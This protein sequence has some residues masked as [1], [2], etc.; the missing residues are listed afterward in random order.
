[1]VYGMITPT[2]KLKTIEIVLFLSANLL[3]VAI[4]L[5]LYLNHLNMLLII[6]IIGGWILLEMLGKYIQRDTK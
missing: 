2:R 3:Y 6:V 5:L 4:T 1:M